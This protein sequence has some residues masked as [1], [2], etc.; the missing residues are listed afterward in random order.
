MSKYDPLW[1][2][3]AAREEDTVRLTFTEAESI[4]G[5]PIDHSFLKYKK[6]LEAYGRQFVKL[7]MK[8]G[9]IEFKRPGD[10]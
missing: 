8:E 9:L 3:L 6:E 5:F 1:S 2:A 10:I 4:L 7:S